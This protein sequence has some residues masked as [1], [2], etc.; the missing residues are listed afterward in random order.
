MISDCT[1]VTRFEVLTVVK[2][3]VKDFW[4]V[5]PCYLHLHREDGGSMEPRNV[6]ILPQPYMAS[7][8]R[9]PQLVLRLFN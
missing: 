1:R 5:M 2:I 3:Q 8:P 4:V 6:C 7:Q 9:R